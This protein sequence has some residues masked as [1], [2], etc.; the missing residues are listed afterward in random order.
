M[1]HAN[2]QTGVKS[3]IVAAFAAGLQGHEPDRVRLD[4][5]TLRGGLRSTAVARVVARVGG[6]PGPRVRFVV[7]RVEGGE[8]REAEVYRSLAEHGVAR[9]APRL[10]GLEQVADSHSYLYLEEVIA[11]RRWPWR[12]VGLAGRVLEALSWVHTSLPPRPPFTN[13]GYEAELSASA[14]ATLDLFERVSR[15]PH[16]AVLAK[17]G[18][19]LRRVVAR[20]PEI[21]RELLSHGVAVLHG[22]A[23][24]GNVLVRRR[25]GRPEAVLI[26]WGSVRT[27][28]PFEDVASWL[29]SLAY[30]EPQARRRH[31]TLL[32]CYLAAR[33]RATSL[34]RELRHLYWLAAA[35]NA[36]AGALRYHLWVAWTACRERRRSETAVAAARDWL[37]IVR[38]ADQY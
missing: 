17:A 21:R 29:Q 6:S 10:L 12:D 1:I 28:S 32:S 13:S 16:A 11:W 35:C 38:R 25:R 4:I 37:R 8:R 3:E 22:D 27:G 7:K 15:E 9:L 18:R 19:H 31:D 36:L 30:R 5:E 14:G 34:T 33:G 26:D 20:L 24:P 23:H 2:A